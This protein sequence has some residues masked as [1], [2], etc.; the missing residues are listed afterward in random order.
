MFFD[1]TNYL[2]EKSVNLRAE[3]GVFAQPPNYQCKTA[4]LGTIQQ[5]VCYSTHNLILF[6]CFSLIGKDGPEN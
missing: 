5:A 1:V 3:K 6:L 2:V 4:L